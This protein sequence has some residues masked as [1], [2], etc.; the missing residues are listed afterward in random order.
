MKIGSV[1]FFKRLILTVMA[2]VLLVPTVI[3]ICLA[4]QN[5][6]YKKK[7]QMLSQQLQTL[8]TQFKQKRIDE[9]LSVLAA[10]SSKEPSFPYQKLYP[11]M[12]CK[13]V[14]QIA[15]VSKTIYLTFDDGPSARTEEILDTLKKENIKAT[16]FVTGQTSDAAKATMKR[17]VKEGHTLG[18]HTYSHKYKE[19]YKSVDAY[20]ADFNK[21]YRLIY[22]TTGQK[23]TV[24]RFPGGSINSYNQAIY[25]ETIAEM[26]RRGF[27]YYDWNVSAE[28]AYDAEDVESI[29]HNILSRASEVK[30]GIVLMHDAKDKYETVDALPL[31]IK[32]LREKGFAF[33]P[34]TNT[35]KTV[36]F[37]YED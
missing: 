21:I 30:N 27:T 29:A 34:L 5:H 9:T 25:K 14:T 28:D 15:P 31:V 37:G 22:D 19:I 1:V 12:M 33:K 7:S 13:P 18:I 35:V 36:T 8:E 32:G 3:S 26:L 2:I 16:F 24:F 23:A 11:D 20:L 10:Q 4:V 17:I 6:Q